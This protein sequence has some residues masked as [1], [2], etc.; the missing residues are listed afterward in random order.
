METINERFIAAYRELLSI[1]AAPSQAA[2]CA[3]VGAD[4]RNFYALLKD[5]SRRLVKIE[6]LTG[7]VSAYGVSAQWLLTGQGT[8]FG[9]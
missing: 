1:G 7:I 9:V 5:P 2:F 3:K 4:R 8:M 6:W